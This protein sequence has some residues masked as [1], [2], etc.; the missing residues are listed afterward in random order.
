MHRSA[1]IITHLQVE[2]LLLICWVEITE[3][4]IIY[5]QLIV[6]E[7]LTGVNLRATFRVGMLSVACAISLYTGLQ[8]EEYGTQLHQPHEAISSNSICPSDYL[9][10]SLTF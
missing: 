9:I 10:S 1:N 5:F 3:C 2:I 6:E 8:I 7:S 4:L